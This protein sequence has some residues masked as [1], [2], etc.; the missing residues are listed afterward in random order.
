MMP[1]TAMPAA[2]SEVP[3]GRLMKGAEIFMDRASD[4]TVRRSRT[5][6]VSLSRSRERAGLGQACDMPTLISNARDL[7][8]NSTDAERRLWSQLRNRHLAGYRFRRQAP[9]GRY[10]V[11]FV[12]LRARLVVELDGSQHGERLLQDF[13]R[14]QHLAR[15]G[16]RVMRFW[17]DEV[18]LQT[19]GVLEVILDALRRACPHP[20]PLPQAGEGEGLQ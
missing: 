5:R 14:T 12:C 20:N 13:E 2:S 4:A 8:K 3:T 11:D 10:V 1:A 7:R 6:A 9:L 17:N 16:F 19:E 18:L 15:I